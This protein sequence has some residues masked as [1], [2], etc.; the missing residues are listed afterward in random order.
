[1]TLR[2]LIITNIMCHHP[3]L[4]QLRDELGDFRSAGRE[5]EGRGGGTGGEDE[6]EE[7]VR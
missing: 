7:D 6:G 1:M 3:F 2:H 5:G 4:T